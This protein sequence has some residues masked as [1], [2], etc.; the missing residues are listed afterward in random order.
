MPLVDTLTSLTGALRCPTLLPFICKST[1]CH[2]PWLKCWPEDPLWLGMQ[3][4]LPASA[5]AH[6]LSAVSGLCTALWLHQVDCCWQMEA[7]RCLLR[8]DASGASRPWTVCRC[9]C[10]FQAPWRE[11]ENVS[12]STTTACAELQ[13][14]VL[15]SALGP[16]SSLRCTAS[17]AQLHK[18]QSI[19][20]MQHILCAS[21]NS[22]S[23]KCTQH[24]LAVCVALLS[25][26]LITC[27]QVC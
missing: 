13:A 16:A 19:A 11:V 26:L 1:A 20:I 27:F 23:G 15:T 9:R 7:T 25:L 6:T 24:L 22:L 10:R 14:E 4:W 2:L 3:V 21:I 18:H 8:R 12:G 17:C 5:R